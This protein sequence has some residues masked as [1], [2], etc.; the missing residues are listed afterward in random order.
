MDAEDNGKGFS[1]SAAEDEAPVGHQTLKARGR[2]PSPPL[3]NRVI[4]Y[5][6]NERAILVRS[7]LDISQNPNEYKRVRLPSRQNQVTIFVDSATESK[8]TTDITT[9]GHSNVLLAKLY[10]DRLSAW[11]R[12][13]RFLGGLSTLYV[14]NITSESEIL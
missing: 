2:T 11:N 3:K 13:F 5:D 12:G 7:K 1:A 4:V 9:D 8:P 10:L 14:K 6:C